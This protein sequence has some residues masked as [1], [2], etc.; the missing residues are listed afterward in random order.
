MDLSFDV[1]EKAGNK[2]SDGKIYNHVKVPIVRLLGGYAG[3][4][5]PSQ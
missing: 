5:L 3:C 4:N 1:G 2:N